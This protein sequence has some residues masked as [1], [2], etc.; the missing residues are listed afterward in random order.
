MSEI[1]LVVAGEYDEY[2]PLYAF[3]SERDAE[4]WAL[5]RNAEVRWHTEGDRA[6]VEPLGFSPAGAQ[7]PAVDLQ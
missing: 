7:P 5:R 4:A 3:G 2:R 1:W 6:R